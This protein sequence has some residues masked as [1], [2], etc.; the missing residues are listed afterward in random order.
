M[1]PV[2]NEEKCICCGTCADV[3]PLDV[4]YGS[5]ENET[6]TVSYPEECWHCNSCVLE[7]PAEGA[8][9]LRIPLTS[10]ILYK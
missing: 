10:M 2:I 9:R 1:P 6:P 7:C 3:C 4:F 8:I 5:R